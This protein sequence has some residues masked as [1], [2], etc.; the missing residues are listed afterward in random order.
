MLSKDEIRL[1]DNMLFRLEITEENEIN[2]YTK[3]RKL[4]KRIELVEQITDIDKEIDA[5]DKPVEK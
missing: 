4:V 3:I 5:L 2:L 1:L